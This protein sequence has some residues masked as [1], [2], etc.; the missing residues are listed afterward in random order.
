MRE[1]ARRLRKLLQTTAATTTTTATA[2][3]DA[4]T[5]DA[6]TADDTA[7]ATSTATASGVVVTA[8]SSA[9]ASTSGSGIGTGIVL[10]KKKSG[11]KKNIKGTKKWLRRAEVGGG[12]VTVTAT[13]FNSTL[14][15]PF[16]PL[17][18]TLP[19]L[20]CDCNLI[21]TNPLSNPTLSYP[22]S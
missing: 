16:I 10:P 6:V 15:Q 19:N 4:V 7:T 17:N 9:S 8:T 20:S 11:K 2:T 22:Y 12:T 1:T 3:E 5:A 18:L 14:N 21:Y 13:F